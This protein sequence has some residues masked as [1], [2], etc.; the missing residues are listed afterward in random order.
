MI[1]SLYTAVSGM[2]S[3]E[4]EQDVI[5]SNL[6]NANT[7]GYKNDN[8]AV[9]KFEDVLLENYDKKVGNKNVKNQIGTL[10]FGSKIDETLTDFTQG[11][12][13]STD[14]DTDFAIEGR[15]FFSV[16]RNVPGNNQTYYTRDGHFHVNT[17]G[18]L[19][20]D[21]GDQVLGTNLNTGAVEPMYIGK[22]KINLDLDNNVYIDDQR[23]YKF[24]MVDFNDYKALRKV[25]DS[26]YEGQN[27]INGDNTY[28]KQKFLERSNVNVV[29]EMVNMMTVMRS[30]ETNQKVIQFIDETLNKAANEVGSVR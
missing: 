17:Q 22:G 7:V 9:K 16:R 26:L 13:A 20:T 8:L 24:N 3:L 14:K 5:T 28:V 4:A 27:P 25:G 2:I 30:F 19:V 21:S 6:A 23:M 1:R 29:N 12:L 10:S 18:F 15:G 11:T